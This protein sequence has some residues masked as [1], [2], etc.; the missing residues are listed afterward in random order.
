MHVYNLEMHQHKRRKPHKHMFDKWK[1]KTIVKESHVKNVCHKSSPVDITCLVLYNGINVAIAEISAQQLR[2]H[3]LQ[4]QTSLFIG[5][6]PGSTKLN[7][8]KLCLYL[9]LHE[10]ERENTGVIVCIGFQHN[11]ITC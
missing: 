1:T 3:N 2:V 9:L 11:L 7:T 5:D 6:Q 8:N 4:P 10:I